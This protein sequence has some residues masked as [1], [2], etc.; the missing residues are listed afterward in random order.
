MGPEV[1][2]FVNASTI[3]GEGNRLR[4][5][6]EYVLG[7]ALEVRED[8][9]LRWPTVIVTVAR[10][11]GKSW[12][13][14]G[15][16]WWRLHQSARFGQQETI[17]HV[18]NKSAVAAEA[19]RPAATL[20]AET[21]GIGVGVKRDDQARIASQRGSESL[22]IPDGSRWLVQ[23]STSNAGVGFSV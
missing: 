6:Q 19:W 15:L 22:T 21:Y 14:R 20:A 17:L 12:L 5:W 8:G 1:V 10:Q 9:S 7:R 4:P 3:L 23:A 2:E 18:A 11:Q 13:L 16:G